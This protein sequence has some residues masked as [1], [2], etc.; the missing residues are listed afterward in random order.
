MA[1]SERRLPC[2]APGLAGLK[3]GAFQHLVRVRR[4]RD[5]GF[6]RRQ[7][8]GGRQNNKREAGERKHGPWCPKP[9][10][11]SSEIS[12]AIEICAPLPGRF[13][14][15]ASMAAGCDENGLGKACGLC[16]GWVRKRKGIHERSSGFPEGPDRSEDRA[17]GIL[18][19]RVRPGLAAVLRWITQGHWPQPDPGEH[20]GAKDD[21]LVR[22][23]TFRKPA[24][25]R[26]LPP[27]SVG[28]G[29]SPRGTSRVGFLSST[30]PRGLTRL[31]E[32]ACQVERLPLA[33][34]VAVPSG[35]NGGA[36]VAARRPS[37][38]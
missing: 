16:Y 8:S 12:G 17:G 15:P 24:V 18:V 14:G 5:D 26:R 7:G 2:A 25:L 4:K 31:I 27:E 34:A 35:C 22:L 37:S 30:T 11:R 9:G 32:E 28:V 36:S 23:Q 33:E 29:R 20:P 10:A 6:S 1:T 19:V 21:R 38:R 3:A 13:R